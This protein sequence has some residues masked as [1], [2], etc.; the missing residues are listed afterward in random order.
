MPAMLIDEL[1]KEIEKTHQALVRDNNAKNVSILK[2][3]EI[4]EGF[5]LLHELRQATE[6]LDELP[7]SL[8]KILA[9][10]WES[11]K[12]TCLSYTST[13]NS[14]TTKIC[15]FVTNYITQNVE[16]ELAPINYLIPTLKHFEN[17]VSRKNI[18][19]TPLDKLIQTCIVSD[20]YESLISVELL[21][22]PEI[23]SSLDKIFINPFTEVPLTPNE[24]GRLTNHS[25]VAKQIFSNLEGFLKEIKHGTSLYEIILK[26][27]K[28]LLRGSVRHEGQSLEAGT[29]AYDALINFR[30][31]WRDLDIID[32]MQAYKISLFFSYLLNRKLCNPNF[33][34]ECVQELSW[35][36]DQELHKNRDKFLR[37][38]IRSKTQN[39]ILTK[40]K[41][42]FSQAK[43][44]LSTIL[45]SNEYIDSTYNGSEELPIT[46][47]QMLEF[48]SITLIR[49]ADDI[50]IM[51][52]I[53][54]SDEELIAILDKFKI[55]IDRIFATPNQLFEV[56]ANVPESFALIICQRYSNLLTT[57]A[58]NN[59]N[60]FAIGMNELNINTSN[61][62]LD[63]AGD[64]IVKL[65]NEILTI[66]L[67]KLN[68]HHRALFLKKYNVVYKPELK[69][70]QDFASYVSSLP[71]KIDHN[72]IVCVKNKLAEITNSIDDLRNIFSVLTSAEDH[73]EYMNALEHKISDLI[74]TNADAR[75]FVNSLPATVLY[76]YFMF[77]AKKIYSLT[78]SEQD[79]E[80]NLASFPEE[81]R[82]A[83]VLLMD[84][85]LS[86][87]ITPDHTIVFLLNYLRDA[88]SRLHYFNVM[89]KKM[90]TVTKTL[91]DFEQYITTFQPDI[92]GY[93]AELVLH[94]LQEFTQTKLDYTSIMALLP[95]HL[96]Y[97]YLESIYLKLLGFIGSIEEIIDLKNSLP[98]EHQP[99][100]VKLL[101]KK[102]A[103]LTITELDYLHVTDIYEGNNINT[104][105]VKI[106]NKNVG[107]TTTS[108]LFTMIA[109]S[110][111]DADQKDQYL[112][113]VLYKL[114]E[115]TLNNYDLLNILTGLSD[116]YKTRYLDQLNVEFLAQCCH[117]SH[118]ALLN[119]VY[120]FLPEHKCN[121][122]MES[123]LRITKQYSKFKMGSEN[124]DYAELT[125]IT[126]SN[127]TSN[128]SLRNEAELISDM[129]LRT[130][131]YNENVRNQLID[132]MFSSRYTKEHLLK[133]F[134]IDKAV[135]SIQQTKAHINLNREKI[136]SFITTILPKLEPAR[137]PNKLK[138]LSL[139]Y[140]ASSKVLN[141]MKLDTPK[142]CIHA[143]RSIFNDASIRF[144]LEK[145]HSFWGW[146]LEKLG[147]TKGQGLIRFFEK[148]DHAR[149]KE[150]LK[151][152]NNIVNQ[153]ERN[154]YLPRILA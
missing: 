71:V 35:N 132:C 23:E 31:Y 3:I 112:K 96:R 133:Y 16:G 107:L 75:A 12:G 78:E 117:L 120:R 22:Y 49:T 64:N 129:T 34:D 145:S 86:E 79:F 20:D 56:L 95:I 113:G 131:Q 68:T 57:H 154:D 50:L 15:Y 18:K 9:D 13:P 70:G 144:Q 123:I 97:R 106:Q 60:A 39:F 55:R 38:N 30:N 111:D 127:L 77:A 66:I 10:R 140:Q 14:P 139:Q 115:L 90:L 142:K 47:H 2:N 110:F 74:K 67:N 118:P 42:D 48:T 108:N 46:F 54:S 114:P 62:L 83:Y 69:T 100:L 94:R 143:A 40:L 32:K 136:E 51:L 121:L 7:S 63:V 85:K 130:H 151:A 52:K 6:T 137:L 80:W 135:L 87:F 84:P 150:L 109:S 43:E 11:V 119:M 41:D 45:N 149:Q 152:G 27:S 21:S 8:I 76:T 103:E 44:K 53:A 81:I 88:D 98:K 124:F 36:L 25:E 1:I 104:Y 99:A 125:P 126:K 89:K 24:M 33:K 102:L 61:I 19:E 147:F 29:A 91:L 105:L 93:Y 128:R 146:I 65:P 92:Q 148:A 82:S 134:K 153:Y 5:K 26:L 17:I 28:G 101:E 73:W 59:P 58:S 37:I 116:L 138:N 72:Y 141:C 4:S 122:F